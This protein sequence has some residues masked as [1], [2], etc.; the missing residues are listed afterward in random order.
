MYLPSGLLKFV[1]PFS[2]LGFTISVNLLSRLFKFCIS[3]FW[4]RIYYICEPTVRNIKFRISV[5]WYRISVYLLSG[6][7]KFCISVF[8]FRIS[9]NLPSG[10]GGLQSNCC[11][12]SS[13][14]RYST[15]YLHRL[16]IMNKALYVCQMK[17]LLKK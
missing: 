5:F 17:M 13:S 14:L 3:V 16:R 11:R 12:S 9:V 8:W 15:K 10:F 7:F 2:G 1:F 4:F 6:I